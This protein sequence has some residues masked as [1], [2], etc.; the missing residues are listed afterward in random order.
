MD[1]RK[2]ELEIRDYLNRNR[3]RYN[4]LLQVVRDCAMEVQRELGT[5]CVT[6]VYSRGQKQPGDREF[7]STHRIAA[8]L[9][10]ERKTKPTK[11][12]SD[13]NDVI[14]LTV[15]IQYADQFEDVRGLI[16]R[17]LQR[18]NVLVHEHYKKGERGYHALH[19]QCVSNAAAH[20]NLWC[21]IQI[22]TM[23]HDAWSS[24]MHD[25]TYKPGGRTDAR[26]IAMME[27]IGDTM[28]L[29]ESQSVT[30]RSMIKEHWAVEADL[31]ADVRRS[32]LEIPQLRDFMKSNAT[33]VQ[34]SCEVG[35][36]AARLASLDPGDGEIGKYAA[37]VTELSRSAPFTGWLAS[38]VLCSQC[39]SA[40][41]SGLM[42]RCAE[43]WIELSERV[44]IESAHPDGAAQLIS[45]EASTL[46][47]CF[48]A[49]G[50]LEHAIEFGQRLLEG[51][52]VIQP[53]SS[54]TI[55]YNLATFYIELE[56]YQP[57]SRTE[58]ETFKRRLE[59]VRAYLEQA[60]KLIQ[61]PPS[62]EIEKNTEGFLTITFSDDPK[63]VMRGIR[64]CDEALGYAD[65]ADKEVAKVYADF[66][67][68]LGWRK[69]L[70]LK[71]EP[72]LTG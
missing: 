67:Q 68:R 61:P 26:L 9:L 34:F 17:K 31:R 7:K 43:D 55:M 12:I 66:Y 21:E 37:R 15:V 8:K 63:E 20:A 1:E 59:A 65:P 2:L 13:I 54:G 30:L 58:G 72:Q 36:A 62:E 18:S 64:L 38:F 40:E 71:L 39:Q 52:I 42:E 70:N 45:W 29:A 44:A 49:L 3:S 48:Y 32:F 56:Y 24:K 4:S 69:L 5:D 47:M 50:K 60:R 25:L 28:Q 33:L 23:L 57:S 14:G 19:M 27:A 51:N 35:K 16:E 11:R 6:R 22:K 46:P 41:L 53:E 10:R